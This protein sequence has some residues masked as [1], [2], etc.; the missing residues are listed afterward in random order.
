MTHCNESSNKNTCETTIISLSLVIMITEPASKIVT[1][2]S[3]FLFRFSFTHT[4]D[5]QDSGRR[6]GTIFIP[7]YIFYTLKKFQ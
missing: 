1:E 6:E 4:N 2:I 7:L 5:S 3:F